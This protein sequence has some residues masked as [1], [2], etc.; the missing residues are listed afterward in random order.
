[1]E[2]GSLYYTDGD[3]EEPDSFEIVDPPGNRITLAITSA[4]SLLPNSPVD[5][6]ITGVAEE[7]INGGEVTVTLPTKA[8]MDHA[9]VGK[10][11][12]YPQDQQI[13]PAASYQLPA[14]A[15]GDSW[16][17]TVTI[18][19]AVEGYYQVVVDAHAYGPE[20]GIGSYLSDY[21]H[22]QAWIFVDD[23]DGRLMEFYND[24]L[25]PEG[26]HPG[27]VYEDSVYTETSDPYTD[28]RDGAQ[29][30]GWVYFE[31][32]YY[33]GP[34]RGLQPATGAKVTVSHYRYGSIW[35]RETETHIVPSHGLVAF[36]CPFRGHYLKGRAVVPDTDYVGKS[37][38]T[39]I[40]RFS[41]GRWVCGLTY[42][43]TSP[44][45]LEGVAGRLYAME[46]SPQRGLSPLWPLGV[47]AG[48]HQLGN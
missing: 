3:T 47:L 34:Q 30:R 5:L 12:Y 37:K 1:M 32:M 28:T 20:G 44:D 13:P 6:T 31:V 9:G 45:H 17:E 33:H 38:L 23:T 4:S 11:L 16:E 48:T 15:E 42:I 7:A 43:T 8:A 19:A 25:W 26:P 14:M 21:T 2:D 46:P 35:P 18:P 36:R 27:P 29:P 22:A 24:S 39:F 41:V 10:P 40:P